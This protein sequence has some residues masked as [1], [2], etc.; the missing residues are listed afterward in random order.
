MKKICF[1]GL[2]GSGKSTCVDFASNWLKENGIKHK[3]VRAAY[4]LKYIAP[5]IKLAKLII[6][7]KRSSFDGNYKEYLQVMRE[8]SGNK[9]TYLV[10]KRIVKLEYD[11]QIFFNIILPSI[12]GYSL[13]IDRYIFDNAVTMAANTNRGINDINNTLHTM[14]KKAPKT[15]CTIYIETP[16]DVC[17]SRKNDIPDRLYLDIRKPLY[18]RLAAERGFIVISGEQP[19]D[20]M[21]KEISAVL[22]VLYARDKQ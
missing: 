3:R 12:L 13:V 2:D 10:Y 9:L 6:L 21:F 7:N 1:V 11:L 17:M 16:V 5:L 15:D 19:K 22:E 18:D 14:W 4:V 8:K 20:A